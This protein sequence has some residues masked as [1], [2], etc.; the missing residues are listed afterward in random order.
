MNPDT[1]KAIARIEGQIDQL[2]DEIAAIERG[3]YNDRKRKSLLKCRRNKI[4]KLA[5]Q[6]DELKT[7][8]LL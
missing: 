3:S 6:L 2:N 8:V 7:P 1:A 5:R 4:N